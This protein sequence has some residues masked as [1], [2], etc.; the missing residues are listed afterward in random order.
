MKAKLNRRDF[1][2][3]GVSAAFAMGIGKRVIA[4]ESDSNK[5]QSVPAK[6]VQGI[7]K[8]LVIGMIKGG[9]SF[10]ETLRI[11]KDAG[12][13][14]VQPNT[15]KDDNEVKSMK[16]A[17]AKVG[18]AIESLICSKHWSMPLSD[19]DP[20]KVEEC[21]EN[22]RVTMKQVKELGG[23]AV[24]LVPAVVNPKVMYRDAYSRS[25]QKIKELAPLAEQ[26]KIIIAVE[27]VWNKFLLSPIEFKRYIEEINSPYV[28]VWFDVGNVHLYGY[29]QDWI[30]TLGGNLIPHIHVKDFDQGKMQ[31]KPLREG[32]IDWAE[33]INALHEIGF[34]G[35]MTA[36]VD[37]GDLNYLK[38]VS[39]RMDLI[40]AGAP[41]A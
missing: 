9:N 10:E 38:D 16:D 18:I 2:G 14:A 26:M 11:A 35:Y 41:K 20:K 36:E 31:W 37:G 33:V 23:D 39:H 5:V 17:A 29:P 28:K 7:K 25:Q 30:R 1:M 19:P 12:F 22:I 6:K 8:S 32:T 15:L 24:L 4:A 34:N 27:D 13:D 3:A 21:M 40:I